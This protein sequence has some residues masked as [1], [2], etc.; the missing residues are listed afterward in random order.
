MLSFKGDLQLFFL[1]FCNYCIRAVAMATERQMTQNTV[2]MKGI[3]RWETLP[4]QPMGRRACP[5]RRERDRDWTYRQTDRQTADSQQGSR[6]CSRQGK[7]TLPSQRVSC[8]LWR[9]CC[10]VLS[11]GARECGLIIAPVCLGTYLPWDKNP[12]TLV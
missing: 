1:S 11:T 6:G 5:A 3:R 7:P 2:E 12:G 9:V 4:A 8:A 10:T